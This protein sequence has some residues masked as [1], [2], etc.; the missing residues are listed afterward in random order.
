MVRVKT[1]RA[2]A[3]AGM[4]TLAL[5]G[6]IGTSPFMRCAN[7]CWRRAGRD[8]RCVLSARSPHPV[9]ADHRSDDQIRY[10]RLGPTIRA[11]AVSSRS[12]RWRISGG[13][14]PYETIMASPASLPRAFFGDGMLTLRSGSSA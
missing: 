3:P 6:D 12:P 11:K 2:R 4:L 8:A 7:R 9:V 1:G 14:S 13:L 5:G 10:F